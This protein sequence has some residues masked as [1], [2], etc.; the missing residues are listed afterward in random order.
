ML[1][2]KFPSLVCS[3]SSNSVRSQ[4]LSRRSGKS[5]L[6]QH[7]PSSTRQTF[8]HLSTIH[9]VRTYTS[10]NTRVSLYLPSSMCLSLFFSRRIWAVSPFVFPSLFSLLISGD[11]GLRWSCTPVFLG[12][13]S[14]SSTF[15]FSSL[16][17]GGS[18]SLRCCLTSLSLSLQF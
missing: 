6:L 13:L 12:G 2:L 11:V 1:N 16:C 10:T 7:Q 14:H 17:V 18:V 8:T 3:P 15:L 4:F 5:W 9:K